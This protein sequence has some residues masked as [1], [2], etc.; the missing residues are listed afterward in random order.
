MSESSFGLQIDNWQVFPPTPLIYFEEEV[1]Y[2][3]TYFW[4]G[5]V[6]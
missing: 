3:M 2:T 1:T 5:Q 6:L 4:V